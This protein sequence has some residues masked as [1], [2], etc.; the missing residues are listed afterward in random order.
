M[1]NPL[2]SLV[3]PQWCIESAFGVNG[4][5]TRMLTFIETHDP[6][7]EQVTSVT[8]TQGL[9]YPVRKNRIT[10]TSKHAIKGILDFYDCGYVFSSVEGLPVEG[11][12]SPGGIPV[13]GVYQHVWESSAW[14]ADTPQT[15]TV[16][17]PGSVGDRVQ[18]V[19]GLQF[20]GYK[21]SSERD[22]PLTFEANAIAKEIQDIDLLTTVPVV[23]STGQN[24]VQ[25]LTL[26]DATG[27]TFII[28]ADNQ[29]TTALVYNATAATVQAALRALG[30]I[31]ALCTVAGSA[32]GP[33]AITN[34]NGIAVQLLSLLIAELTPAP[35][36]SSAAIVHTT[37]G[38]MKFN[39]SY[40]VLPGDI[41]IAWAASM[42]GLDDSPTTP[43]NQYKT[44]LSVADR[45]EFIWRQ[46]PTDV[47]PGS[48][49]EKKVADQK[50]VQQMMLAYTS[51][52]AAFIANSK[53]LSNGLYFRIKFTGPEIAATGVN[54]SL[55]FDYFCSQT[56][57]TANAEGQ[58][59]IRSCDFD[60]D[61]LLDLN[62]GGMFV[63]RITAINGLTTYAA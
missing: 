4:A 49:A 6:T 32:G 23:A 28:V 3:K 52:I 60:L 51:E 29:Q 56:W 16:E 61:N 8:G 44:D 1:G 10:E 55:T 9:K 27:G 34:V 53:A 57:K 17:F 26:T 12:Y 50:H 14:N 33:Y 43:V 47:G 48:L 24:D 37:V 36:T 21:I 15:Y 25:T 42:A 62:G 40:E 41:S 63:R 2:L 22:K 5:A 54:M 46:N 58:G 11:A 7:P 38:G 13:T 30:G 35:P 20:T 19:N 31:W 59:N 18:K 45:W 39:P